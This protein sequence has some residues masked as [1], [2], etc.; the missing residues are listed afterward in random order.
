MSNNFCEVNM[1]TRYGRRIICLSNRIKRETQKLDCM[2]CLDKVSGQNGFILVYIHKHKGEKVYQK[3]I[4]AHFGITRST[5]SKVVTLM[6]QKGMIKRIASDTD[7]RL[8]QLV[9]TEEAENIVMQV[10]A[11]LEE[12][13]KKLVGNLSNSEK[14]MLLSLIEKMEG[15]INNDL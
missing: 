5:A 10:E 6:E 3:D 15:S 9:L 8:K 4:E 2:Q 11:G 12:F 1:E 13:D 14:E 7:A